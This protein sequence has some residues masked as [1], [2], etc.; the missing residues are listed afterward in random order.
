MAKEPEEDRVMLSAL[1]FKRLSTTL[2]TLCNREQTLPKSPK[3]SKCVCM[4]VCER[5]INLMVHYR[6]VFFTFLKIKRKKK[7][8]NNEPKKTYEPL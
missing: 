2:T 8:A 6:R 7:H 5:V 1:D 4:F 3:N